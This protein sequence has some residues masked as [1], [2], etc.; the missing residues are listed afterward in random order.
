[1]CIDDNILIGWSLSSRLEVPSTVSIL[2]LS[3]MLI[4]ILSEIE[5]NTI[6]SCSFINLSNHSVEQTNL[7][8]FTECFIYHCL[9]HIKR[10]AE[11]PPFTT[12]NIYRILRLLFW[13]FILVHI[14]ISKDELASTHVSNLFKFIQ[15]FFACIISCIL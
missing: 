15:V 2:W 7:C 9:C 13:L 1:M 11:C 14:C 10:Q 6:L 5:Y 3:L 4:N 8:I 12:L